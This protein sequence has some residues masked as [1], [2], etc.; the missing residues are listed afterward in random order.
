VLLDRRIQPLLATALAA[1][2]GWEREYT[3]T[4]AEIYRRK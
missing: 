4:R 2:S 3:D 1:D